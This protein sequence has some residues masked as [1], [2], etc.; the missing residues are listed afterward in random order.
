MKFNPYGQEIQKKISEEEY[1][2]FYKAISKEFDNALAYTHFKAEGQVEFKSIIYIPGKSPADLFNFDKQIQGLQLFVKKVYITDR[3]KE[4]IPRYLNFIK[5]VIDSEDLP[6]H[7]S[8]QELQR[9][10]FLNMIKNKIVSRILK[11]LQELSE[12]EK[13]ENEEKKKE[14]EEK[15][16]GE[17]KKRK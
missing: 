16:E 6:L 3:M 14:D 7:I 11:L 1:Q 17:E 4:Y 12:E 5:G 2:G 9:S 8:R 15:K 13:R 10:S